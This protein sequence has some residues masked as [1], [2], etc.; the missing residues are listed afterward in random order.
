MLPCYKVYREYENIPQ[1]IS[2]SF[3]SSLLKDKSGV[4]KV[5]VKK[6]PYQLLNTSREFFPSFGGSNFHKFNDQS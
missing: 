2:F 6:Q 4:D 3:F 1:K 5:I